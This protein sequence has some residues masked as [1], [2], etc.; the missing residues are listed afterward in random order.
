MA[1]TPPPTDTPPDAAEQA[2]LER[3]GVADPVAIQDRPV[4]RANDQRYFD[5]ILRQADVLAQSNVIPSGYRRRSP[6]IVAAGLAGRAFGWDIMAAMR[7]FH[8]VEGTASMRPEAM[9]GLVRAAGHSVQFDVT[10]NA[11]S[12]QGR[13]TDNGDTHVSTFSMDDAATA[14][15]AK[16]SNWTSY[17]EA[18]LTWRAVSKLCRTLFPDVVLGAGLVPEELDAEVGP[19]GEAY[20]P[21]V[22]VTAAKTEL[23]E[24]TGG[25]LSEAKTIWGSRVG[26]IER[27][28]LDELL[29]RANGRSGGTVVDA[30]L[31]DET[32]TATEETP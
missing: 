24:A 28:E 13:R 10:D 8:V 29:A 23:V 7:N 1:D 15:L 16:K 18:M 11:V 12:A 19:N 3:L 2:A 17:P 27:A 30:E 4:A 26:P 32:E 6:D 21:R 9:L 14:G 25:D 22:P 5:L 31:V 20:E